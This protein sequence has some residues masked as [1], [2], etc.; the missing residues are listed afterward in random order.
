MKNAMKKVLVVDDE[1]LILYSL[2]KTLKDDGME[3]KTANNGSDAIAESS[4]CFYN[5]CFLDLCLPDMSGVDVMMK[6]RELSP[7]C[8]ILVMS[9][10]CID[11][12]IRELIVKNAYL[13]IPKPFELMHVKVIAHQIVESGTS[14]HNSAGHAATNGKKPVDERRRSERTAYA[15]AIMYNV[16][17]MDRVD[18]LYQ[19]GQIVDISKSGMGIHPHYPS[20]CPLKPGSMIKFD[21]VKEGIDY[22]TGIVRNTIFNNNTYRAGIEFV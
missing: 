9:A 13:F 10:S 16:T 17:C 7:A 15:K 4:R 21:A 14:S 12:R 19:S 3:V 11:D 8:K 6:I 18:I 20:D 22:N 2:A 1:P 5:L